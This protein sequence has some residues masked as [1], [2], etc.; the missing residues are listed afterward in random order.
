M[1]F[2]RSGSAGYLANHLA[3]LFEQALARRIRPLGLSPGVFPF[4]LT[5]WEREGRTQ[6]ELAA[7]ADVEQATA[8]NTLNRM[9]RDGLIARVPNPGDG[10]SRLITLTPRARGLRD[11]AEAAAE[12]A[13]AEALAGLSDARRAAWSEASAAMI[14]D[15]Q[16]H[17]GHEAFAQ[18]LRRDHRRK[19]RF[20]ARVDGD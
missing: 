12:A 7:E 4:L 11:A 18:T 1:S 10:R 15:W 19:S 17:P 9:E 8:A 20:W 2:Q 14:A 16:G 3:R 5:L 13:N 6:A